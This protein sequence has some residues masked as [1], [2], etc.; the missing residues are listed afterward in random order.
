[1]SYKEDHQAVLDM[2]GTVYKI[3][4]RDKGNQFG[5]IYVAIAT[6]EL[7]RVFKAFY[8][9]L[10]AKQKEKLADPY[11]KISNAILDRAGKFA[12]IAKPV[13]NKDV[14]KESNDYH[15]A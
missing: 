13:L 9:S 12:V 5:E 6:G 2:C 3:D 1:M 14:L 10:P 11:K 8:E 15:I 4:L 7:N